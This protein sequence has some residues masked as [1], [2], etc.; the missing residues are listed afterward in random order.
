MAEFRQGIQRQFE[1]EREKRVGLLDGASK[2]NRPEADSHAPA[3]A[4]VHLKTKAKSLPVSVAPRRRG[5]TVPT[6]GFLA[7]L[8]SNVV[9]GEK[10]R[11]FLFV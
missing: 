9:G 6:R 1:R 4:A 8:W 10:T 7:G 3:R 11:F 5:M 2:G